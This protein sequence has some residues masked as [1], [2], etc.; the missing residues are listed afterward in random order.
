MAETSHLRG[1]AWDD[2]GLPL[3]HAYLL[4]DSDGIRPPGVAPCD[5]DRT[6]RRVLRGVLV[7]LGAEDGGEWQS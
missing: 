2:D 6:P 1:E 4:D 5:P 3:T 7:A